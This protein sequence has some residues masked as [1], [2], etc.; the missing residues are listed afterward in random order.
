[1][2]LPLLATALAIP[3]TADHGKIDWFEGTFEQA[4]QEA[5]EADRLLFI[6]FW[7]EW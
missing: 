5:A 1:M 6:D 2:L 4:L 3:T 7:T